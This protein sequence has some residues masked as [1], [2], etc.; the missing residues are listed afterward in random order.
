MSNFIFNKENGD[1]KFVGDFESL[2]ANEKDPW[3]QSSEE[4]SE[5]RKYYQ[6]SRQNLMNVIHS[7][8]LNQILEVGCGL[9]KTTNLIKEETNTDIDGLDISQ[10]AVEKASNKY[11]HIKFYQGDILDFQFRNRYK[12]VIISQCLWYILH[13]FDSVISNITSQLNQFGHILFTQAFLKEQKYG[14]DI[15]DGYHGL[16]EYFE[17][18][19]KYDFIYSEYNENDLI[20]NDGIVLVRKNW[21]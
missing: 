1:I 11:R 14:C 17:K 20:H 21:G 19:R 12:T 9:G 5:M 7:K 15:I 6:F 2:Y 8:K 4:P 13:N 10:V 18:H 3:L 16:V